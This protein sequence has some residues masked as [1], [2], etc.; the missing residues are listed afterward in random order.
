MSANSDFKIV[1]LHYLFISLDMLKV[2]ISLLD[3][4]R[5]PYGDNKRVHRCVL[6]D[7]NDICDSITDIS[8]KLIIFHSEV[9]FEL[10]L[11]LKS[12]GCDYFELKAF[13]QS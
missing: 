5:S 7:S 6:D 9:G 3:C 11:V 2:F 13:L 1:S 8:K 12:F 4:S 10:S